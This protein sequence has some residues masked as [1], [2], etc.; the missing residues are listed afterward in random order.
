M[1]DLSPNLRAAVLGAMLAGSGLGCEPNLPPAPVDTPPVVRTP[2]P[3]AEV[4]GE[5]SRSLLQAYI[6]RDPVVANHRKVTDLLDPTRTGQAPVTWAEESEHWV[7]PYQ[8]KRL[9]VAL[10]IAAAHD[11]IESLDFI[12]TPDARWGWPD[13]R[14]PGARP[15]FAGD[16]GERFFAAFRTVASRLPDTVEWSSKPVPP[17]LQMLHMTGAEPMWTYYAQGNDAILM[18]LVIHEGHARIAYVGLHE[19]PLDGP[20]Q[21]SEEYGPPPPLVPPLRPPPGQP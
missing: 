21:L 17:G 8:A 12:L 4:E 1:L 18:K 6:G 2:K 19:T 9:V 7:L 16:G 5:A 13:P 15:V 10:V 14:M 3:V 11:R 20:P